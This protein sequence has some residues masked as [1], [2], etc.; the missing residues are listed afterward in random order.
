MQERRSC[1]LSFAAC[2]SMAFYKSWFLGAGGLG[3]SDSA[4]AVSELMATVLSTG[5]SGEAI[6]VT[7]CSGDGALA[8][9]CEGDVGGAFAEF[10]AR[11]DSVAS[12]LS[13]SEGSVD[14]GVGEAPAVTCGL[15][16]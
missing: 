1:S 5:T 14:N 10:D 6:A 3:F 15:D 9:F 12:W 11:C 4:T 13:P 16:L 2:F 8:G 7:I